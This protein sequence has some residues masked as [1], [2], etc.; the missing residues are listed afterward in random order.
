M[1]I[2][3]GGVLLVVVGVSRHFRRVVVRPHL[4]IRSSNS[5]RSSSMRRACSYMAYAQS[6]NGVTPPP[7]GTDSHA[8]SVSG[9]GVSQQHPSCPHFL[10]CP[11]MV[12]VLVKISNR[13]LDRTLR[14]VSLAVRLKIRCVDLDADCIPTKRVCHARR[15]PHAVKWVEHRSAFRAT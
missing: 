8:A 1:V 14:S 2:V 10:H 13:L 11:L 9:V 15:C 3:N 5:S 4:G 12:L 6:R 7:V